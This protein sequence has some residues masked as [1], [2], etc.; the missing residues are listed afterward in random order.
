MLSFGM[1]QVII[2]NLDDATIAAYREQAVRNDRSLE[3]ELRTVLA[4]YQPM[5]QAGRS[6]ALER[7]AAIRRMTPDVPQTPSEQL[8]R[9]DRDGF[10]EA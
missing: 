9:E 3:A 2:R 4:R 5:S 1:G 7:L 10:R 8:V 6:A